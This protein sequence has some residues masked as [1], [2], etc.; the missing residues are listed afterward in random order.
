MSKKFSSICIVL[1]SLLIC[2]GSAFA[3]HQV[4]QVEWINV[5]ESDGLIYFVISGNDRSEKLACATNGYW[6]I[7]NENSQAGRRQLALLTAA[8]V[9]KKNISVTGHHQC[10]RWGDGEDV[11][12]I[13]VHQ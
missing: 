10:T 4:G 2:M 6:M 7:K 1:V 13:S 12:A 9:A 8:F 5:R 11:N 3:S